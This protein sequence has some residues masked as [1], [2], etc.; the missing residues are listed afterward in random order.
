MDTL[1]PPTKHKIQNLVTGSLAI[2]EHYNH[3]WWDKLQGYVSEFRYLNQ[4]TY[5]IFTCDKHT[6]YE[7]PTPELRLASDLHHLETA[8]CSMLCEDR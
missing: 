2:I 8:W 4:R 7:C 6:E 5:N 3:G 1:P